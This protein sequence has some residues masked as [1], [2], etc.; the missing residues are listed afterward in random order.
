[1][2]RSAT[3]TLLFA[4]WKALQLPT[5]PLELLRTASSST[6]HTVLLAVAIAWLPA[7]V[8]CAVQG[9][10]ALRSFFTDF[11]AQSRFWIVIPILILAAPP[12]RARLEAV[13]GN[14]FHDGLIKEKDSARFTSA[15]ESFKHL[16]RSPVSQIVTALLV[17]VLAVSLFS[18]V[19]AMGLPA[20]W[21]Y[22]GGGVG[23][24]SPAGVWYVL[25]S[26]PIVTFLLF[27]WIWWQVLW[28]RFLR[29]VAGMDLR[30]V[31]AHPDRAAGLGFV[32]TCLRGYM[33]FCFA[34][35][36]L[37]AGGVA[38]R[39]VYLHAPL[40]AFQYI[41]LVFIPIVVA[42]CVGPLCFFFQLLVRARRKGI[43]EYGA[44]ASSVGR[45][46]EQRWIR[47]GS[48]VDESALEAQ[49]FSATTDLYSI[50]ANVHQMK[51]FPLGVQS[52]TRLA[53]ATLAPAVPVIFL[54]LPFDVIVEKILRMLL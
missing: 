22:G 32:E 27:R 54:A 31:A 51:P 37:V 25:I 53:W 35:G 5:A 49:D 3:A 8:L 36:T 45:Q 7:A 33:P 43:V 12:L 42:I 14:F 46:F 2:K 41:P 18:D 38:N 1:M 47:S 44:L 40:K 50:A 16:A 19:Q 34:V 28:A 15:F 24:L 17:L 21:Y 9:G 20:S 4:R 30:L 48:K 29:G 13:A 26:L 52:L 10:G 11:A 39:V 23:R 6:K